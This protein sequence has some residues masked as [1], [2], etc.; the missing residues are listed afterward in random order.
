MRSGSDLPGAAYMD[1]PRS[2]RPVAIL[3]VDA[4]GYC[5][6]FCGS[7]HQP[8]VGLPACVPEPRAALARLARSTGRGRDHTDET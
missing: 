8:L 2:T 1:A 4:R 6:T 3:A 5:E 7:L